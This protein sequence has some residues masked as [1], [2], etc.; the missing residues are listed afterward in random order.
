MDDYCSFASFLTLVVL[1]DRHYKYRNIIT[2][3]RV[4][5][6]ESEFWSTPKDCIGSLI[7]ILRRPSHICVVIERGFIREEV[8]LFDLVISWPFFWVLEWL[9]FGN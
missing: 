8:E 9:Q 6:S 5:L 2:L 1:Q 3:H 7:I 4:F